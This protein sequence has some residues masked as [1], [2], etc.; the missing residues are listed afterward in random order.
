M[1][2]YVL[3]GIIYSVLMSISWLM[4]VISPGPSFKDLYVSGRML[5]YFVVLIVLQFLIPLS[6]L[7]RMLSGKIKIQLKEIVFCI[8]ITLTWPISS[9]YMLKSHDSKYS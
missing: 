6:M 9:L 2:T 7:I 4:L 5:S 3:A 1:N 8:F